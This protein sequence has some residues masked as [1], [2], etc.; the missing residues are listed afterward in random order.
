MIQIAAYASTR[1]R[2]PLWTS[3]AFCTGLKVVA[4]VPFESPVAAGAW[5][6]ARANEFVMVKG[7]V[8]ADPELES[9]L[10]QVGQA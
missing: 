2:S 7:S 6:E 10:L 4:S 3:G 5:N 8:L 1:S 9:L